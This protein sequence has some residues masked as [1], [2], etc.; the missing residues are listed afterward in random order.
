MRNLEKILLTLA[1]SFMLAL[2]LGAS[3][4]GGSH[5]TTVND[6]QK[7][8]KELYKAFKSYSIDKKDEALKNAKSAIKKLDKN[9]NELETKVDNEWSNM[10]TETRKEARADLRELRETRNEL[11]RNYGSLQASS[12]DAW[13]RIKTGFTD[14]YDRLATSWEKAQKEFDSK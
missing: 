5:E 6:I 8:S 7:E 9:I 3:S 2:P 11:A 14:A 12:K 1:A 10:T 4:H 13:E